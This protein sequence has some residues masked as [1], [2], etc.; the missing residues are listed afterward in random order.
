MWWSLF[1]VCGALGLVAESYRGLA[2]LRSLRQRAAQHMGYRPAGDAD[3][4]SWVADL[5]EATIDVRAGLAR[6]QLVPKNCAK[7]AL[8]VGALGAIAQSAAL[9]SG[10]QHSGQAAAPLF[11]A[12][13]VSFVGG[14]VGAMACAYIG[15]SAEAEGRRLRAEWATLI[16]RS[17]RDVA[18]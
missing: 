4:R 15:R 17:T 6:A 2:A 10:M 5:N 16:Q 9:V 7:A 1:A 13:I 12:P 8:C 14:C 3:V 11:F 18:T